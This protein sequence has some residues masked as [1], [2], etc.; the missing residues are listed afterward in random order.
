MKWLL[1][2]ALV[3]AATGGWPGHAQAGP[4][5]KVSS[6][7]Q[8][9]LDS[10]LSE[11]GGSPAEYLRAI[12]KH[13]QKYPN[14]PRRPELERAA[15]RAAI[16][17]N[18]N[19]RTIQYGEL[20]LARH[21]DD[22]Q[23]LDRLTQAL[24]AGDGRDAS[25]RALRYARRYEELVR[26]MQKDGVRSG[27]GAAEWQNQTA[28]GIAAALRYE[29]RATGNLGR[30][31]EA[32]AL[33]SRAFETYPNADAAREIAREYERL[34]KPGKAAG[35]LADAFT[36]PDPRTTDVDRA[37]DRA[38]MGELWRQAK[39]SEA[40]LGDLL[41]ESYDH[42]VALIHTRELRLRQSDPNAQLTDPM[43]FTLTGLDGQK[44]AMATLKG[45]VMVLDFWATWCVPCRAQHPLYEEVKR[46]LGDDLPVM[47][48]SVNTDEDRQLVKPFLDDVKWPERVYFEDGLS[49]ALAVTTIPTT[50]V[51]D[52]HGRLFSRMN[53]YDP[54]RFVETL[55]AR[56]RNALEN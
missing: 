46:R 8:Q 55:V 52:R 33:A 50:I 18:D 38:R 17:A 19:Q 41:L 51:F 3:F 37:R 5:Q 21:P 23:I 27:V 45:K 1:L 42:N 24:L 2:L 43:E 22:L 39:G 48:L 7:E 34:G 54:A 4:E 31:E 14:S 49:R 13:L 15:V 16:E 40:G 29:A 25:E 12:E 36:I 32:L 11:A 56:V 35:A 20:V 6:Q 44:L 9:D 47:F 26:Q 53:G 10:V 28:R 30:A